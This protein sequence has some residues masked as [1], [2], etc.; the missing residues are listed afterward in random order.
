[1]GAAPSAQPNP[2][3]RPAPS[4]QPNPNQLKFT[5]YHG[6]S[7]ENAR[8]ICREQR[9]HP[10]KDGQLGAG[11]YVGRKDKALGYAQKADRHGGT[12]GVLLKCEVTVDNPKFLK[13]TATTGD[14]K[15]HDAIRSD[16][17]NLSR[18][19]EWVI[20][21]ASNV[22][23]VGVERVPTTKSR[24]WHKCRTPGCPF[25]ENDS[26]AYAN[27]KGPINQGYCCEACRVGAPCGHGG[28]CQKIR[29]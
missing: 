15:G 28:W 18:K 26:P 12:D 20:R 19:P 25:Q 2:T 21:N 24:T 9:F 14:H 27:V 6:T 7:W 17:T 10:S 16:F 23:P 22:R 5:A 11:V 3:Q 8:E 4:A 29:V 1:M 13:G